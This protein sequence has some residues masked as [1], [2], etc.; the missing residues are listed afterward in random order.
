MEIKTLVV[1]GGIGFRI[2]LVNLVD[3]AVLISSL[4]DSKN[5]YLRNE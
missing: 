2:F 3:M 4:I 5:C 1:D